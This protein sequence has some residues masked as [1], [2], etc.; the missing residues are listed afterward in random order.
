MK[1]NTISLRRRHLMIAGLVGMA[2]PA[3]V[4]A[5]QRGSLP[6]A[7]LTSTSASASAHA[8]NATLVLSGRI[9]G[10][11]H[12]PVSGAAIEI[13]A[14]DIGA[15]A[16]TTTDADGRFVFTT[17][18][19]SVHDGC[20]RSIGYRISHPAHRTLE[21]VLDFA[22]ARFQCDEAGVWR[23]AVGLHLA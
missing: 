6:A 3:G 10:S 4:F 7:A 16:G 22:R 13:L 12:R 2:V 17:T 1:H 14:A 19:C 18:A 9:L 21:T 5:A 8:G 11:D 15:R 20:P 23:A